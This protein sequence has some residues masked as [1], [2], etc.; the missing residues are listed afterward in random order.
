MDFR[1]ASPAA[2]YP[3]KSAG[4]RSALARTGAQIAR[5]PLSRP[6]AVESRAVPNLDYAVLCD[7]VRA[8]AGLAHVIAAG[9]DTVWTPDVPTGRNL[10]LLMR[11]SFRRAECGRE[12]QIEIIFQDADGERLVELHTAITPEWQE[13]VPASWGVGAIAGLN[14]GV[15]L[16][17]FG[18]YSF[19][20][21]INGNH[22]KTV[23][24][25]LSQ[26]EAPGDAPE[27][28]G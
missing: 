19:E 9:I 7:Y 12:H 8:E 20:I 5:T 27:Q 3:L 2:A 10:G 4:N 26:A 16:P 28:V 22:V 14:F 15:P 13:G 6:E 1:G 21:L 18:L 25:R 11:I 23:P 17:R 24:L